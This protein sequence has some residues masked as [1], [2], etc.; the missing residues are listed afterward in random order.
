MMTLSSFAIVID[1]EWWNG[2]DLGSRR[3]MQESLILFNRLTF[4]YDVAWNVG[5]RV[6]IN[7]AVSNEAFIQ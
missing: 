4:Q 5:E 6:C 1:N 7:V 3:R 2:V